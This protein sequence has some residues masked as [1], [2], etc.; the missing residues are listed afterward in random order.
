MTYLHK[1]AQNFIIDSDIESVSALSSGHIN[2]TFLVKTVSYK[3]FV[4]QKLNPSVFKNIE[5]LISNKV[6]VSEF[7]TKV[8]SPYQT[9]QFVNAKDKN[10]F[11]KD[12]FNDYWMLMNYIQNSLVYEVAT[13]KIMVYEAGKLY[14][15][16]IHQC[17]YLDATKLIETLPDF[18]SMPFRFYQFETAL[19]QATEETKNL[20]KE[21]IDFV[22]SSKEDMF[23]LSNLKSQNTFP[24]RVTHNDA[25]LSNILFDNNDKGFAIIDLDTVMPGI[26]AFDFGDSIRSIC[27][28]T[29]EDDAN[30]KATQINLAFYEAYCMGFAEH[31]KHI[32]TSNEIEYLPLG[33][34]TITFMQGLRFL[35]D[36]LNGNIYYKT[37]YETHNLIRAKN[38]FKLVQ[39]IQENFKSLKSI[40]TEAF[41]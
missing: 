26:V 8:D 18:H 41:K 24:L 22:L 4:L 2:D 36:F 11:Y 15:D 3:H 30:L 32:L 35:T 28:T 37:N 38:Q 27:S 9:V 1:V 34:K 19:K 7:L 14:G 39:S 5:G 33:A 16:F 6:L 25:K 23:Q 13:N 31:T 40:I 17:S 29:K 10:F 21:E 12:E 20:S